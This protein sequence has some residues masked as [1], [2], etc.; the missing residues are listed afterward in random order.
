[1]FLFQVGFS[2]NWMSKLSSL[3]LI[4]KTADDSSRP[5]IIHFKVRWK[6]KSED[7]VQG[8]AQEYFETVFYRVVALN[9]SFFGELEHWKANKTPKTNKNGYG[10]GDLPGVKIKKVKHFAII[11]G[12]WVISTVKNTNFVHFCKINFLQCIGV[13]IHV[14]LLH[15][16][17]I[18]LLSVSDKHL[19]FLG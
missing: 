2:P 12:F 6:V 7:Q 17:Q 11:K 3:H 5:S 18:L 4:I 9:D 19:N 16:K 15:E 14:F 8:G 1:M 13:N 10:C